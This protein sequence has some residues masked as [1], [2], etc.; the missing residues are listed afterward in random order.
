MYEHEYACAFVYL[1]MDHEPFGLF[2]PVSNMCFR[3]QV[4]LEYS[5]M[6]NIKDT[7]PTYPNN[8]ESISALDAVFGASKVTEH[9]TCVSPRLNTAE[10]WR[11]SKTF[12]SLSIGLSSLIPLPSHLREI[13]RWLKYSHTTEKNCS[14]IIRKSAFLLNFKSSKTNFNN[15]VMVLQSTTNFKHSRNH[16]YT[17]TSN[18][19]LLHQSSKNSSSLYHR[20]LEVVYG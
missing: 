3:P 13:H 20:I 15:I 5:T 9:M 18:G 11:D 19:S 17:C 16:F 10:P 12:T 8:M 7:R 6:T 14:Q 1:I 2:C 4:T